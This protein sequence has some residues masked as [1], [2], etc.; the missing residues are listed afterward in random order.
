VEVPRLVSKVPPAKDFASI[1]VHYIVQHAWRDILSYGNP[2]NNDLGAELCCC[3]ACYTA[4]NV[5]LST[6][7]LINK[8]HD[9]MF[10]LCEKSECCPLMNMLDAEHAHKKPKALYKRTNKQE[11]GHG[12]MFSMLKLQEV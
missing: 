8:R 10:R 2:H 1:K 5:Y 3:Y 7:S 11:R 6:S 9:G 12:T 4:T